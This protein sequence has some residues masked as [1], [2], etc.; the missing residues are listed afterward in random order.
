MTYPLDQRSQG[1]I[2]MSTPNE[3]TTVS[4]A[5]IFDP[6]PEPNTMPSGWD[7]SGLA[8]DPTPTSTA[9]AEDNSEA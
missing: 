3:D 8:P 7:L 2:I 4:E 5:P 6:F 9:P 1:E